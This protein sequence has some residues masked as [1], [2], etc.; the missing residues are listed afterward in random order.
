[1][2]GIKRLYVNKFWL[3]YIVFIVVLTLI[4]AWGFK[5]YLNSIG[6]LTFVS[7]PNLYM[8]SS[9]DQIEIAFERTISTVKDFDINNQQ[10]RDEIDLRYAILISKINIVRESDSVNKRFRHDAE[11]RALAAHIQHGLES[12]GALI[13]KMEAGLIKKQMVIDQIVALRPILEL[14]DEKTYQ[15]EIAQV[16]QINLGVKRSEKILLILIPFVWVLLVSIATISLAAS[17]RYRKLASE[18]KKAIQKKNIFLSA[19]KHELSTPLQSLIASVGVLSKMVKTEAGKEFVDQLDRS[20]NQI[21]SQMR[22]LSEYSRLDI[23]GLHIKEENFSLENFLDEIFADFAE[24]ARSKQI[25]L[26]MENQAGDILI[27]GDRNR[28]RQ[29]VNNLMS[30][31]IKFTE[32]G[33]V[34]VQAVIDKGAVEKITILVEDTGVGI[35]AEDMKTIFEPFE[36]I[37][38]AV[39]ADGMGLGLAIVEQLV[40]LLGG[41]IVVESAQGRGSRFIVQLPVVVIS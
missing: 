15:L 23:G 10:T 41:K 14:L 26:T 9:V 3:G 4:C 28:M 5:E 17:Q 30:N 19:V 32:L 34:K 33:G 35:A 21:V 2:M 38:T 12:T 40:T 29:I 1:M 36:K 20:A 6:S 7:S 27:R 11:Y 39:E 16:D 24:L 22:D 8:Y 13:E 18:R 37:S 31:S 25:S